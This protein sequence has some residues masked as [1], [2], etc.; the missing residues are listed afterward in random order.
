MDEISSH[1]K[2]L[3]VAKQVKEK[4]PNNKLNTPN[5]SMVK[6]VAETASHNFSTRETTFSFS[7]QDFPVVF[8]LRFLPTHL[9]LRSLSRYPSLPTLYLLYEDDWGRVRNRIAKATKSLGETN[10]LFF[11]CA[12][13]VRKQ[14]QV[15]TSSQ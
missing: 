11:L 8:L 10:V 2:T 9:T 5:Q 13:P 3:T 7:T 1:D 4:H 15:S 6:N 12:T 14:S